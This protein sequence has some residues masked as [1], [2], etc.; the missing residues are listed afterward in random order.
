MSCD[1]VRPRSHYGT[2]SHED[3]GQNI[4]TDFNHRVCLRYPGYSD[5]CNILMVLPALDHPQGGI[6]H[7]TARI[8]CSIVANNRWEG[9]LTETRTGARASVGPNGILR[10]NITTSGFLKM[11]PMVSKQKAPVYLCLCI[12]IK[13]SEK[14]PVVPS[15][16][17]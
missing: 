4:S 17:H 2:P 3:G 5:T 9:F 14:Y 6:H 1:I 15:F 8:A 12:D 10:R 7:E 16:A 11:L 13:V